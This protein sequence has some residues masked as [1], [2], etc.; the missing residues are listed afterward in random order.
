[1]SDRILA[2]SLLGLSFLGTAAAV[3]ADSVIEFQVEKGKRSS[4]Q[5]VMIKNGTLLVKA[6]GGDGNLDILYERG[7]ERLLL[8][9]HKKQKVTPVT[10][11]K[12]GKIAR[13]AE[14]L[15]PVLQ[16]IGAQL[17]KLSPKQ[18]EKW[19]EML[20]GVHLEEFEA[21]KRAAESTK[22]R[23]TGVGKTFAGINC[24]QMSVIKGNATAAEF[25]LA[26]PAA[27]KLPEDDAATLRALI[28]F[29][30][31]LAQKAQGL[32]A[33]FGIGLP[34]GGLAGLAGVPIEMRDFG[35]KRPV[36]MTL[37]RVT[38][39]TVSADALK[40]PEGYQTKELAL[41]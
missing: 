41:W 13:Q 5:P 2:K 26:D 35:G 4:L 15:Q 31:K 21:A 12:V 8:I 25:C 23:K 20:G 22:L 33:Q 39:D 38:G 17:R 37:S 30:Q 27:L 29:T 34:A 11:E 6:A 28:A 1:M 24:E 10:D 16:G 19:G 14:E 7:A 9:D 3:H 36:A 40:V 18:R 32:T